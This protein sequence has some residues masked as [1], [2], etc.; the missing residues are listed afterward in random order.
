MSRNPKY[1]ET[2]PKEKK[3]IIKINEPYCTAT[4][5]KFGEEAILYNW[6]RHRNAIE[7]L[8][9]WEQIYNPNFKPI[10][11]D[12]FKK[13]AGPNSFTLSPKKWIEATNAIGTGSINASLFIGWYFFIEICITYFVFINV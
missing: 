8:G 1:K 2:N 10:E 12:R 5:P 6:L 11:F 4:V 9:I 3:F 7:F 13:Q